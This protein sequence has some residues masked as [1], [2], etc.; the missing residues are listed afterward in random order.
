[1]KNVRLGIVVKNKHINIL[2]TELKTQQIVHIKKYLQLQD[3]S[4]EESYNDLFKRNKN[5]YIDN[6]TWKSETN[7]FL[8]YHTTTRLSSVAP[9]T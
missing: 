2:N 9:S 8:T 3:K 4:L 1:M 5:N 6:I 7:A